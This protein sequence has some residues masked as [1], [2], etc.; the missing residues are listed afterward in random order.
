VFANHTGPLHAL[1]LLRNFSVDVG[2]SLY[3][4]QSSLVV[5]IE[6]QQLFYREPP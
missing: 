5:E 6:R 4:P 1:T 3:V 2:A